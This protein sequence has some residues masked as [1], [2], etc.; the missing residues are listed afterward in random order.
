MFL[1]VVKIMMIMISKRI[2]R[3]KSV[4]KFVVASKKFEHQAQSR[5]GEYE[6]E[7][8]RS[9][10]L[11]TYRGVPEDEMGGKHVPH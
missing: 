8:K 7:K 10:S 1:R 6:K 4:V 2:K 11:A 9:Q 3:P 5:K